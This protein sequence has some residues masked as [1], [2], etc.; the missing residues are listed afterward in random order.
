MK[1]QVLEMADQLSRGEKPQ[2][3]ASVTSYDIARIKLHKDYFCELM[4]MEAA[5]EAAQLMKEDKKSLSIKTKQRLI[6]HLESIVL[7]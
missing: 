4:I 6:G 3:D 2:L 5:E 1:Q 7:C